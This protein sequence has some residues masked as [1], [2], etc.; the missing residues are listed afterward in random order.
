MSTTTGRTARSRKMTKDENSDTVAAATAKETKGPNETEKDDIA[1]T[2]AG[3]TAVAKTDK[4]AVENQLMEVKNADGIN[5]SNG[6]EIAKVQETSTT[7][8]SATVKPEASMP[9]SNS[10]VAA[11][12]MAA[13]EVELTANFPQKV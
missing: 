12:E 7:I 9:E 2:A 5:G 6:E 13:G 4:T 8:D 10:A 11:N 3:V 1:S